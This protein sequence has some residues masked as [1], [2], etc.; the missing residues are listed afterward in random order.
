VGRKQKKSLSPDVLDARNNRPLTSTS[1]PAT[2]K[3]TNTG[4]VIISPK[5]VAKIQEDFV[6][7]I[8]AENKNKASR[9]QTAPAGVADLM[10]ADSSL[11]RE[12][13]EQLQEL[14]NKFGKGFI[15]GSVDRW[16]PI[17]DLISQLKK[18]GVSVEDADDIYLR[19]SAIGSQIAAH[20]DAYKRKFYQPIVDVVSDLKKSMV[21][22]E[23][24]IEN[25]S[26]I[27]QRLLLL[28]IEMEIDFMTTLLQK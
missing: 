10:R 20:S 13:A 24:D 7:A 2:G 23:R 14:R 1:K 16:L 19:I 28:L 27:P 8:E 4:T 5:D 18:S 11:D 9:V 25:Y 12:T 21:I 3:K 6:K 15:E 26:I 22:S 17:K